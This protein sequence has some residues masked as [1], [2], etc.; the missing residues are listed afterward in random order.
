[1]DVCTRSS[2]MTLSCFAFHPYAV[3][4]TVD[5]CAHR[6]HV[7]EHMLPYL[8]LSSRDAFKNLCEVF[9]VLFGGFLG[10]RRLTPINDV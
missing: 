6:T 8:H 9:F 7:H 5:A 3:F 1:M 4:R 10:V 2:W